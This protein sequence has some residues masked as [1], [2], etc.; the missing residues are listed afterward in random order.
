MVAGNCALTLLHRGVSL[1]V[2]VKVQIAL[3]QVGM[4][5][6]NF[7]GDG[8][9]KTIEALFCSPD[10]SAGLYGNLT[11]F[12]VLNSFL[13]V[14]AF[15]GNALILI[16]L[17]K[18]SSP[19]PPSKLLLRCLSTTDLCV[20]LI[21]EPLAVSYWMS[22][23]DENW[24]ICRFASVTTYTT[25]YIVCFVSVGTLAAI[26]VDRPLALLLA[27]RYRQVVALKRTQHERAFA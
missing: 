11:F 21:A 12:S 1:L 7:T 10:L 5:A 20:G 17:R 27:L 25:S 24:N 2:T 18:E 23:A 9:Q 16:A 15:L 6:P 4:A 8:Q 19:H 26:S 13:S 3:L 14:T 22:I